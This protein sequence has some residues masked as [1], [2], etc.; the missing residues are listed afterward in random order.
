MSITEGRSLNHPTTSL[1]HSSFIIHHYLNSEHP[2]SIAEGRSLNHPTTSLHHSTFFI[3]YSSLLKLR[4]SNVNSS[5]QKF[6][7]SNNHTSSFNIHHSSFIIHHYLNSEH[8]MSI[9][10]GRSLNHPTTSLH[11]SIFNITPVSFKPFLLYLP[12]S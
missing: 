5:R 3:R 10:E 2:M 11:H 1:H 6:E 7:S 4:T 9:A 8:P 12:L